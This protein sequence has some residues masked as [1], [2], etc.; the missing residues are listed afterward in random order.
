ML[1]LLFLSRVAFLCNL[2]FLVTFLMHYVSFISNGIIPS[3]IIIIGNVLSVVLNTLLFVLY[4]F[5]FI[6][7]RIFSIRVPVWLFTTNLIFFIFQ[8]ILLLK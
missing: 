2:C 3:T 7:S 1:K 5:L 4:C 6:T 8:I